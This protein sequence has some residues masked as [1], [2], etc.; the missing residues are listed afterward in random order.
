MTPRQLLVMAPIQPLV[1]VRKLARAGP[2]LPDRRVGID[3]PVGNGV[4]DQRAR[5]GL[6]DRGCLVPVVAIAPGVDQVATARNDGA[7]LVAAVILAAEG[8]AFDLQASDK[9]REGRG[10]EPGLSG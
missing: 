9:G 4:A 10:V 7:V 3:Q 5:E 2:V 8:R 1:F 6:A